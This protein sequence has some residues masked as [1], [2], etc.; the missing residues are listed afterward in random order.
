M[1][2]APGGRT[3]LG[4]I[5]LDSPFQYAVNI[6]F[7]TGVD[8]IPGTIPIQADAHFLATHS[9]YESGLSPTAMLALPNGGAL[10]QVSDT[11]QKPLQFIPVPV[12]TIFG[13]G[14][15]PYIWPMTKLF[16]A[17]GIIPFVVTGLNA[18]FAA[19]T[20]RFVIGGFKVRV[21]TAPE[22]GL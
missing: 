18:A 22:F 6:T 3:R 13:T 8:T 2:V 20:M 5:R 15:R 7:V 1:P 14:Q 17:N 21:N 12:T 16:R 11:D 10:V 9:M 4:D 19:I